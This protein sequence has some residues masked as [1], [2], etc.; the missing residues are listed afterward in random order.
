[1]T[2]KD[3]LWT[4][5]SILAIGLSTA[6]II[7]IASSIFEGF[8]P[9]PPFLE[10]RILPPNER[11]ILLCWIPF[12]CLNII[13]EEIMWRGYIL[14]RQELTHRQ[15]TWLVHGFCW[16]MFHLSFGWNLLL[17]LIPI[18]FIL[19]WIV[20]RRRNTWIG[21]LIHGIINGGGFLAISLG[22]VGL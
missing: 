6:I 2:V 22:W 20:Q 21:L 15:Q 8:S 10:S 1:M 12:F 11:W 5:G 19:S 7:A 18:I 14:P 4:L 16:W 3:W 17:M 9:S 13:G